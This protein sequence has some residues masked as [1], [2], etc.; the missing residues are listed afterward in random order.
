[1]K[2]PLSELIAASS[3]SNN[4]E[5][6]TSIITPEPARKQDV[7]HNNNNNTARDRHEIALY[8][9]QKTHKVLRDIERDDA[10]VLQAHI[11]NYLK[12]GKIG[13]AI[14]LPRLHQLLTDAYPEKEHRDAYVRHLDGLE[15]A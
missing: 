10:E 3:T 2:K 5:Q 15:A 1:M 13:R 4:E 9:H 6:P 14:M 8:L 7:N 12:A 11:T